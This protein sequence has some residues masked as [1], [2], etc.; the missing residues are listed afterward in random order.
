MQTVPNDRWMLRGKELLQ[1]LIGIQTRP[2]GVVEIGA[3]VGRIVASLDEP[4]HTQVSGLAE[5]GG[6]KSSGLRGLCAERRGRDEEETKKHKPANSGQTPGK[7]QGGGKEHRVDSAS[8]R[9]GSTLTLRSLVPRRKFRG[10]A[11]GIIGP[12]APLAHRAWR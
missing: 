4:N 3:C 1:R 10:V 9:C 8:S 2:L 5:R 6:V 12:E 7:A 11:A